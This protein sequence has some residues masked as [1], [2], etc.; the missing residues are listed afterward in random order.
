MK[1]KILVILIVVI[2]I[3]LAIFIATGFNKRTDVVLADYSVSEDETKLTLKVSV[4][5]SMGYTRDF[6]IK[7]DGDN[8]Y[9]AF[10]S[11]FGGFNSKIGA[12]DTFEIELN[13]NCTSI[14][15]YKGNGEYDLV[16]EKDTVTN[17]WKQP[18]NYNL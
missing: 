3:I 2:L 11:T 5:S 13:P 17:I 1:K 4:F 12:K 15:F 8:Q 16:L 9:I 7:Q 6:D 14:Y 10:Y 18:E